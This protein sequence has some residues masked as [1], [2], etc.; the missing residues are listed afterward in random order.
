M[1]KKARSVFAHLKKRV[2]VI[3]LDIATLTFAF[4]HK[5]TPWYSKAIIVVVAGYA[6]SPIDLIPDF[7]PV[8]GLLD[9]LILLPLGILLAVK[10]IPVDV[11]TECRALAV[12]R[13]A[14][15]R[16]KSYVGAIVIICI[17][18]GALCGA[19]FGLSRLLR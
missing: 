15:P 19:G 6:L 3:K 11:L 14:K 9:D 8:L 7:I 17:W 1:L 13:V 10:T 18:L 4:K 2:A 5:Q 16:K 12:A